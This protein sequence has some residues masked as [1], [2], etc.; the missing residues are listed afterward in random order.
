M[1]RKKPSAK[2]TPEKRAE[3]KGQATSHRRRQSSQAQDSAKNIAAKPQV[4][5]SK[6]EQPGSTDQREQQ[7]GPQP[8]SLNGALYLWLL[9]NPLLIIAPYAR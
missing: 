5:T 2:N 6:V 8:S 3:K 4:P 9:K 1:A 7:S